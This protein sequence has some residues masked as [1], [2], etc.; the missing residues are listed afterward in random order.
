MLA[1]LRVVR[2]RTCERNQRWAGSWWE[3]SCQIAPSG[4]AGSDSGGGGTT[5]C[6]GIRSAT[7]LASDAGQVSNASL[8]ATTMGA[9]TK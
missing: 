7:A 9:V 2:A 5:L 3:R 6:S 1:Q 4:F 8:R